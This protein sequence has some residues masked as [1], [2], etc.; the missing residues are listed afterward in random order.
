LKTQGGVGLGQ[1]FESV[2]G[3]VEYFQLGKFII[4]DALS[5]PW[6]NAGEKTGQI[7]S[8][9]LRRFKVIFNYSKSQ[10]I[11]EPG[12]LYGQPYSLLT[13][14]HKP[15]LAAP[16]ATPA[17]DNP[18]HI[19]TPPPDFLPTVPHGFSVNVFARGFKNPR[20]LAV[21]PNGDVLAS[22]S[23]TNE[24]TILRDKNGAGIAQ[25]REVFVGGL[26]EP[27][28]VATH[29]G[30]LY[31]ANTNEILRYRFDPK[32]SKRTGPPEHVLTLPGNGYNQHWTRTIAFT[33]DGKRLFVS[34]GSETDASIESDTRRAAVLVCDP[35]G[36]NM[37][38]YASGLRNAVGLAFDPWAGN[39]WASVNERDG[40]GDE[41]PPDYF[42]SIQDN[43]FY[44]WPY[45]YI[46]DYVDIRIKARPELVA[47][48]IVPDLLLGAHVAPLQI[49]FYNNDQF[50]EGYNHG[51]FLVEHGSWNRSIR[52]GYQVVYIPFLKNQPSSI[53]EP[54][55]TGFVPD[56]S[57][58]D[59]Y[60]RPAGIAV[61]R[62]GAL[63][64]SDD[65]A[66]VI[67]RIAY[68][69]RISQPTAKETK[70]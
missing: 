54:F 8:G 57:K 37:R 2:I 38:V 52:S 22:D 31:V 7:G 30:Y 25:H 12:K 61:A 35:D 47:K 14:G 13:H 29:N 36:K 4:Y 68:R 65:E 40:L 49:A 48:A 24:I 45:S 62:D 43:G 19:V 39:L 59:V 16:N 46:G 63:L 56:V 33:R 18:P 6:G 42:T 17:S 60:G 27:F 5:L 70:Y 9:I 41:L 26:T 23:T 66:N 44:G 1:G 20:W 34:V 11:L 21:A 55:L 64:V 15:P 53:P 28:A 58:A 50:P 32:T 51:A 3:R 69:K 10:L 67:Y